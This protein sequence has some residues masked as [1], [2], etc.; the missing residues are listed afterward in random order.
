MKV[1]GLTGGI[2]TGVTTVARMFAERGAVVIEADRIARE[3]VEPGTEAYRKI[4]EAFGPG[5]LQPD[6][7]LDRRAL[8]RLVFADEAARRRLNAITHP[9]IRRRIR[10]EIARVR[11]ASPDAVVIIDIP[12]LLDTTGPE[13]FDLEGVIVV[14]APREEQIRRLVARDGLTPEE[15]ERRVAAQRPVAEKEA[16]ADWVIDNGGSLEDTRRQVDILWQ[17]LAG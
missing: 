16:E 6:G 8:A 4:V 15:A 13:A 5:I 11:Q 9:E 17:E 10:E 1:I 7:R 3:V 12:L 14:T 2:A